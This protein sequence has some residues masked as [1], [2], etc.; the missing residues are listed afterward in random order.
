[1]HIHCVW[2]TDSSNYLSIDDWQ[3]QLHRPSAVD[4]A[5]DCAG[6]YKSL[7]GPDTREGCRSVGRDKIRAKQGPPRPAGRGQAHF[8]K[9]HLTSGMYR[10]VH[11]GCGQRDRSRANLADQVGTPPKSFYSGLGCFFKGIIHTLELP[12]MHEHPFSHVLR[13]EI[14]AHAFIRCNFGSEVGHEPITPRRECS[15]IA[16]EWSAP[17]GPSDRHR[18]SRT[19]DRLPDPAQEWMSV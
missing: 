2:A 4:T 13:F 19:T 11:H 6:I 8:P 16:G 1:M 18:D 17:A 10:P 12:I 9:P 7:N 14:V 15:S 3:I 5:F